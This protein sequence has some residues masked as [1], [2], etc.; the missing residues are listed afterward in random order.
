MKRRGRRRASI[1]RRGEGEKKHEKKGMEGKD[2][3]PGPISLL[4]QAHEEK[5]KG[6]AKEQ[7]LHTEQFF[8]H[9]Q[10]HDNEV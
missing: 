7:C 3:Q 1:T 8:V 5:P 4:L 9:R 2:A 6:G 10:S